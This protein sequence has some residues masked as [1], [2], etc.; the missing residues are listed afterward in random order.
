MNPVTLLLAESSPSFTAGELAAFLGIAAFLLGLVLLARKVFGHDPAL[1]MQ[2]VAREDHDRFREETLAE[3]KRHASRRAE[4]Y[5]LQ[6]EHGAAIRS[7][8]VETTKQTAD[9]SELKAQVK[10]VDARIDA[11]PMRTIQ[12]LRETQQLHSHQK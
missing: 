11:V 9:L 8:Q 3:L 1:H 4:I 10:A 2:Y 12:L 7:L 6:T 5:T